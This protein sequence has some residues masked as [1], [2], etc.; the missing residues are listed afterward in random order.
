M[1]SVK[2]PWF[3][4]SVFVCPKVNLR[5][6]DNAQK[7]VERQC[8]YN[9]FDHIK[10]QNAQCIQY[11]IILTRLKNKMCNAFNLILKRIEGERD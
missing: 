2:E 1:D 4:W 11:K 5:G 7:I 3:S 10:K 6:D 8:M 9:A